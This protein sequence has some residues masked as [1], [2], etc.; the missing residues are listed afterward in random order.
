M[1]GQYFRVY[2]KNWNKCNWADPDYVNTFVD[3]NVV[4]AP[5]APTVVKPPICFGG[6]RTLTVTSPVV[7]TISWYAEAALTTLLGTGVSYTPTQTAPGSYNFW[8]VDRANTGLLCQGPATMVTLTINP[9]PN[10]PTITYTGNLEFCFDGITSV[11]LQANV[12]TPPAVTSYQWYRNGVA[13]GRSNSQHSDIKPG[14]RNR[15]LYRYR[16]WSQS[17]Q[18][19]K[20]GIRPCFSNYSLPLEPYKPCT[21]SSLSE[22]HCS[23]FSKYYGSCPELAM[24]SKHQRRSIFQHCR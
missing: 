12:V 16:T 10:K 24:G 20:S 22:R 1:A 5:P 18:L 7:G 9:L 3:I 4:A 23:F 13:V 17:Y 11:I 19:S 14:L 8:V 15:N 21:C 6:N 2:L